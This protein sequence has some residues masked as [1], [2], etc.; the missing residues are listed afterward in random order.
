MARR[1]NWI[2]ARTRHWTLREWSAIGIAL[3]L[4]LTLF[5]QVGVWLWP[6]GAIHPEALQLSVDMSYVEFRP[7]E[8]VRPA[9]SQELSDRIQEVDQTQTEVNW[10]NAVDPALDVNQRYVALLD[11]NR[12]ANDY[13]RAARLANLG[14]VTVAVRLYID[15]SGRIRDVK[16]RRISS[17]GDAHRPFQADFAAS[18]RNVLLNKTRVKSR[19]YIVDGQ[20]RDIVWDTV[21]AFTLDQ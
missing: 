9:D 1:L 15:G 2:A 18:V 12:D 6:R 3:Q 8:E 11:V 5:Y 13:P 4:L 20:A 17:D 14:R 21:I 10:N 16:I 19:P 7:P